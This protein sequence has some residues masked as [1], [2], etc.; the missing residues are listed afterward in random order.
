MAKKKII[1][2]LTGGVY[3]IVNR[4]IADNTSYDIE[5][6]LWLELAH[7]SAIA[8]LVLSG[9]L[10]VND[11]TDDLDP[12]VGV[13]HITNIQGVE[14]S[15]TDVTLLPA[16][17]ENA[18][19]FVVVNGLAA[20]HQMGV[21][22]TIYGQSRADNRAGGNIG[23][24]LHCVIDNSTADRWIQFEVKVKTTSGNMDKTLVTADE[25][26]VIGPIEVPTTPFMIFEVHEDIPS[27]YFS[28]DE[29]YFLF[30]VKRVT[31][32]GKTAPTNDVIVWR[33]C[34]EYYK[35]IS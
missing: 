25:T 30:E 27:S 20:G 15:H 5:P 18:P 28:N 3:Q 12:E 9:D 29:K 7:D 8:S 16:V 33:Y 14:K 21:N 4:D 35:V 1:K 13:A 11:G 26:I 6:N 32:T 10:S 24:Q 34:K 2:N 31:A 17:G 19:N 22:D 23:L